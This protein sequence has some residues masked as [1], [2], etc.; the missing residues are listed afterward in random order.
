MNHERFQ[1]FHEPQAFPGITSN[2]GQA[3]DFFS[4]PSAR[5]AEGRT[6]K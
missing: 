1:E 3:F 2:F 5:R 4:A 6:K